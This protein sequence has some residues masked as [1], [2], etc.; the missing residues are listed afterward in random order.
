MN[1]LKYIIGIDPGVHNGFAV[2]CKTTRSM[3]YIKT[4]HFWDLITELNRLREQQELEMIE[5]QFIIED[6]SQNR[7]TF[8]KRS[9]ANQA[10]QNKISQNV[11]ENKRIAKLII[12]YCEFY[13]LKYS[14]LRPNSRKWTKDE[15]YAITKCMVNVSQHAIDAA[16]LVYGF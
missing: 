15:F 3:P 12:E 5:M 2:W 10:A 14:A 6:P 9:V 11:G 7:P 8:N 1:K 4:Y 13:K 16:K